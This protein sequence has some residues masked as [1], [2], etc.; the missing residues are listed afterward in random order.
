MCI[1]IY[2]ETASQNRRTHTHTHAQTCEHTHTYI[3]TQTRKHTHIHK[4]VNTHTHKNRHTHTQKPA[5]T[6]THTHKPAYTHK[7]ERENA[8][9]TDTSSEHDYMHLTFVHPQR[10]IPPELSVKALLHLHSE[11][12]P[13]LKIITLKEEFSIQGRENESEPKT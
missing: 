4:P 7:R 6:H 13:P 11:K 9:I 5:H 12:T 2:I 8:D 1:Y 10:S 3:H